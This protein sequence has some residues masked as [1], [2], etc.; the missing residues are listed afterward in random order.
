MP[1]TSRL[2]ATILSVAAASLNAQRINPQPADL[3]I[4]NARIYTVDDSHPFVSA[5][6]VRD[7]HVAFV[8]SVREAMVLRGPS[9]RVIDATGKTI[10]PGMT[11]AHAHLFG[12]GE[13]LRNIDLRD[14]RSYDEIVNIIAARAKE[15]E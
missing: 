4:T 14:T 1:K 15:T 9:T 10:I 13:F 8:G 2:A 3:I 11:D 5:L 6:A 12:L 7:G